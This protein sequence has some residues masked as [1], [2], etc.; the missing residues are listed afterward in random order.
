MTTREAIHHALYLALVEMRTEAHEIGN[1]KLF[2]LADLMHNIP[3]Q[4]ER[5]A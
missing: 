5:V 4:L 3:L 2:Y 1:K